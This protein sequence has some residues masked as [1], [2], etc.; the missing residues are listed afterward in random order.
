MELTAIN[1]LRIAAVAALGIIVIGIL[2]WPLAAPADPLMAVRASGISLPDTGLLLVL[3]F[4]IG[5]AGYF[6]SW[7]HGREIGILGVPFG[8]TVWAIRSGPMQ[9]LTQTHSQIAERVS[10]V[11]SLRFEPFYWLLVVAAGFA[12]VLAA[13][14]L[15]PSPKP[16]AGD[17]PAPSRQR[18]ALYINGSI[19][20]AASALIS[21]FF[22]GVFGQNL[23]MSRPVAAQPA[24][25]QILFA[26]IGAFAVAAFVVK[27]F[28]DASYVW[29][30]AASL[31]VIALAQ[32]SHYRTEMIQRFAETCPA[33]FFPHSIFAILPVQLVALGALGSV[34]GYW[35][36]VRYD[37]WRKHET[38]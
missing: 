37:Y 27:K 7:P 36:A 38:G 13:Q 16:S 26:V 12:G 29:P 2:A 23:V 9:A 24:V 21:L 4:A 1:K 5:F 30:G 32:V 15:R 6:I 17:D 33:T 10:L 35:M 18:E 3:A 28:L 14:R 25:G 20:L 19:A 11:H 34:L 22:V 8:L 31:L